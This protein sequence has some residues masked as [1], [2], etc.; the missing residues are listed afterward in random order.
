MKILVLS[1]GLSPERDVSLT[2][3][4]LI[5]G[6]L[7]RKG[8]EVCAADLYTGSAIHGGLPQY[9][10]TPIPPYTVGK[11][12]PDLEALMADTGRGRRRIAPNIPTLWREAD[13]VFIALH[14]DVGE[15]GQLQAL[16]DMEC[17]PYTG[18]GYAGSLLAMDKDLSKQL[19]ARVGVPTPPWVTCRLSQGL[20]AVMNEIERE[21]GYPCVIKPCSCGSSVGVSPVRDRST[22]TDALQ[23]AAAYEDT[24]LAERMIQGREVTVGILGDRVLPP[25]EIIPKAGFYDYHNKYQAGCTEEIC[26]ADISSKALEALNQYSLAAFKTLRLRGYARFDYILDDDGIPWCLEANTLPGMTPLSL[27]PLSAKAAGMDYDTL[28]ETM[29]LMAREDKNLL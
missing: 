10:R 7:A 13:V 24:V 14:G 26:P 5:A 11:R 15:N 4:S 21:I 20:S 29:A 6:A 9:A 25:V 1:G 2:S 3:G 17:I 28:C 8:H 23:A 16:L 27:L 22:L 12:V 19:L 18:T